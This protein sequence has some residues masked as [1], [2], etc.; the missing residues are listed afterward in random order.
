MLATVFFLSFARETFVLE[1]KGT[2]V[3]PLIPWRVFMISTTISPRMV[4]KTV[5]ERCLESQ[6]RENSSEC[7]CRRRKKREENQKKREKKRKKTFSKTFCNNMRAH[8][9]Y[10]S[11]PQYTDTQP[12]KKRFLRV[13]CEGRETASSILQRKGL[14]FFI[15]WKRRPKS[16]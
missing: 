5:R 11:V 12:Q 15:S 9:R 7:E 14:L 1:V 3:S 10:D 8:R 6:K 2:F 13:F 4:E 16:P